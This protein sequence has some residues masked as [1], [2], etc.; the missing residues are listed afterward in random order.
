MI[1]RRVSVSLSVPCVLAWAAWAGVALLLGIMLLTTSQTWAILALATSAV[2]ATLH[3]RC[4]MIR[5]NNNIHD[6]Y[7][8]GRQTERA[9]QLRSM[10]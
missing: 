3:M 9:A 6:V 2:A 8:L 1:D 10:P 4:F 7:D 5:L